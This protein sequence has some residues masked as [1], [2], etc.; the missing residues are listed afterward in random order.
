MNQIGQFNDVGYRREGEEG[1]QLGAIYDYLNMA[2]ILVL[3]ITVDT[4]S[5]NACAR[6]TRTSRR[7]DRGM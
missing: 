2:E 6:M 5:L 4:A 7:K 1:L 3:G